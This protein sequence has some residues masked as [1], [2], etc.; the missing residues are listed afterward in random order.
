MSVCISRDGEFSE[1]ETPVSPSA[2]EMRFIC[3]RCFVFDDAAALAAL[4]AAEDALRRI[5]KL[6]KRALRDDENGYRNGAADGLYLI[7][8]ILDEA[9][10]RPNE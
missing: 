1:H 7:K 8:A 4:A 3:A 10:G 5:R 2:A 6:T 9:K